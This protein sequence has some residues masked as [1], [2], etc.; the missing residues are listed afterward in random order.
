M[1]HMLVDYSFSKLYHF[2]VG[3]SCNWGYIPCNNF[4]QH[5]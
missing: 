5:P 4:S 3:P 1:I 2:H